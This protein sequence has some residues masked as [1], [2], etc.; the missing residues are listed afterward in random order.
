MRKQI[1]IIL[2][3]SLIIILLVGIF[4]FQYYKKNKLERETNLRIEGANFVVQ[5]IIQSISE[6]GYIQISDDLIL[7]KYQQ[8]QN[9][10]M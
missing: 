10:E 8:E 9:N 5:Q 4:G 3:L 6:K 7:I 1:K 2:S